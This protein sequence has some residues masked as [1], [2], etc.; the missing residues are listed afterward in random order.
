MAAAEGYDGYFWKINGSVYGALHYPRE[1]KVCQSKCNLATLTIPVVLAEMDGHSFQCFGINY[2]TNTVH[3]GIVIELEV[4]VLGG[5]FSEYYNTAKRLLTLSACTEGYSSQLGLCVILSVKGTAVPEDS[6]V[7]T[8][9][10]RP[11]SVFNQSR[12]STKGFIL[13]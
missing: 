3:A 4:T 11:S 5:N 6:S 9:T 10:K 7:S 12:L 13:E 8:M 1:Y 2:Q